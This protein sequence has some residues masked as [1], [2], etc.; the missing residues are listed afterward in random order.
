MLFLQPQTLSSL[1]GN[2]GFP[3]KKDFIFGYVQTALAIIP[4]FF[5]K[6]SK[7]GVN[8]EGASVHLIYHTSYRAQ[9]YDESTKLK[10]ISLLKHMTPYIE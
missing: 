1:K 4:F 2:M 10:C 3:V 5:W 8:W 7:E 9:C 6:L